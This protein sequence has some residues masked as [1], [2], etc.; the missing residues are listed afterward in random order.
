LEL[1]ITKSG[2]ET[3]S[4]LESELICQAADG[5]LNAFRK[6]V[7][8]FGPRIH[9]IGY[10]MTGNSEDAKDIAQEVFVKLY[11]SL[12]KYD[13]SY[14]FSTWL[15]RM[16]VNLAIDYK[17]K[18]ARHKYI[19]IDEIN[20]N[21]VLRDKNPEPDKYTE[22]NEFHGAIEKLCDQLSE[23][24]RQV[25]VLRD[26]QGFT[27]DEI[28]QILECK[29]STIRVHLAKARLRIRESLKEQYPS[30]HTEERRRK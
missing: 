4:E 3:S 20:D 15:Y 29:S 5:D 22:Q 8:L 28:S 7:E 18:H 30:L 23:S 10:Q 21:S 17:R 6:C 16:T 27:T 13:S 1:I 25:F 12:D 11:H 2:L 24:Q 14:L 26:L 9:S 19:T